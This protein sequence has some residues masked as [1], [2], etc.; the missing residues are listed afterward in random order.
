MEHSQDSEDN[1]Q[2]EKKISANH[3][4]EGLVSRI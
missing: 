2:H 1:L 3:L 4:T